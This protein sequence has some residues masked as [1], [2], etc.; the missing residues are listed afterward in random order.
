MEQIINQ[1]PE[2]KEMKPPQKDIT[3]AKAPKEIH[4]VSTGIYEAISFLTSV[5]SFYSLT[6][7]AGWI[8]W[9]SFFISFSFYLNRSRQQK[10]S[11]TA[12]SLAT[13]GFAVFYY[14]YVGS[15]QH[16]DQK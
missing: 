10:F 14:Y 5:L 7:Q 1:K 4:L 6:I 16:I 11:Q 15:K 12:I 8:I 2:L 3:N 9:I 13:S